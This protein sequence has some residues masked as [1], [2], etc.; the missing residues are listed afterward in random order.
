VS[1]CQGIVS[2][3]D[4]IAAICR[5]QDLCKLC[6]IGQLRVPRLGPIGQ[7]L[8]ITDSPELSESLAHCLKLM[9]ASMARRVYI[10][11]TFSCTGGGRLRFLAALLARFLPAQKSGTSATDAIGS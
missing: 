5:G 9:H 6:E 2:N 7:C 3:D 8:R 11:L 10:Y 1:L 4:S